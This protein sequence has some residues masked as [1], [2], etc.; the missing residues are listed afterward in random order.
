M[1]LKYPAG[2]LLWA[3]PHPKKP[4]DRDDDRIA[5][6]EWGDTGTR[7]ALYDIPV[8]SPLVAMGDER[9]S[10]VQ[11]SSGYAFGSKKREFIQ[12]FTSVGLVW[13]LLG[14]VDSERR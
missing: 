3:Q 4:L 10:V 11:L 1:N 2:T 12:V 6:A 13:M 9:T 14:A 7:G 8:G 5:W